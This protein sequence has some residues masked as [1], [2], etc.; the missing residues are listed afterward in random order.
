MA[1]PKA[2]GYYKLV[3]FSFG[4]INFKNSFLNTLIEGKCQIFLSKLF[5]SI[6]LVEKKEY[7]NQM[8]DPEA[9]D[10]IYFELPG[11]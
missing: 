1:K 6:T 10:F 3:K 5:H 9:H 8:F 2:H 7:L 4:L 11:A